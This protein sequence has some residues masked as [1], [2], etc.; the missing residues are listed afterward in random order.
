MASFGGDLDLLSMIGAQLISVKNEQGKDVQ[1][2]F[3]PISY[4][5]MR[6][7]QD[8]QGKAHATFRFNM[9]PASNGIVEYWKRQRL[10]SNE[11]ITAYNIPTH[12]LELSLTDEYKKKLLNR[13]KVVALEQHKE[14]WTTPEQQDEKQNRDL[15]NLIY[16]FMPSDLCSS[17]WMHQPK[18]QPGGSAVPQLLPQ[19]ASADAIAWK[20][21]FGADGN[22]AGGSQIPDNSDLPF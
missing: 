9:W 21:N 3:V 20:P 10:T 15:R 8:K 11:A 19:T 2:V 13:A 22:M 4:N 16:S 18:N 14:D 5:Q 7:F 17:V 6:V 1:G 12:R